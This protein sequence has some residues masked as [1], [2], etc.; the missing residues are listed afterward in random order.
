MPKFTTDIQK[1]DIHMYS[2]G[3]SP[4]LIVEAFAAVGKMVKVEV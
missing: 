2:H 4:E 3:A 1:A